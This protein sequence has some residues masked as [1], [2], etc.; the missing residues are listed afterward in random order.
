MEIS[1]QGSIFT[2]ETQMDS[3]QGQ[4]F[5]AFNLEDQVPQDHMLRDID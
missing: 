5:Y 1:G 4:F 3:D 2:S